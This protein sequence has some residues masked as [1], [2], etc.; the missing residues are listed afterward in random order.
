MDRR[1][2]SAYRSILRGSRVDSTYQIV[3]AIEQSARRPR[4]LLN[5]SAVGFYGD[6]DDRQLVES[7]E[8]GTGFLAHLCAEWEAQALRAEPT[9]RVVCMRFGMILDRY[10]GALPRLLRVSE[11]TR[12]FPV[13]AMASR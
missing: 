11:R 4:A 3:R 6:R 2:T 7:D 5:A 9:C 13:C 1:W 8:V 12:G 10:E